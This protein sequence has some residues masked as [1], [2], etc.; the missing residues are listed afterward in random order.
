M[1]WHIEVHRKGKEEIDALS[2]KMRAKLE[3]ILGLLQDYGPVYVR[4]PYVKHLQN[5]LWEIRLKDKDGIG[6]VI[7]VLASKSRIVLLHAFIK[8]TQR[9]PA[10]AIETALKRMK[11]VNDE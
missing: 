11:E 4:E 3:H 10:K 2:L 5:K 8:K 6:R 9:T 7:Y 1:K